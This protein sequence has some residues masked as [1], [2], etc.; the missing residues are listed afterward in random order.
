[1]TTSREGKGFSPT[2][3]FGKNRD[4]TGMFFFCTPV[5]RSAQAC[6]ASHNDLP[7]PLSSTSPRP[8][9]RAR[10]CLPDYVVKLASLNLEACLCADLFTGCRGLGYVK[11]FQPLQKPRTHLWNDAVRSRDNRR[12]SSYHLSLCTR[13]GSNRS[14]RGGY[15]A[16]YPTGMSDRGITESGS[17]SSFRIPAIRSSTG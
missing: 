2:T 3:P 5:R 15:S 6:L 14:T 8:I 9:T 17:P 1:M 11:G 16:G 10:P 13:A 7:H 12:T 4:G